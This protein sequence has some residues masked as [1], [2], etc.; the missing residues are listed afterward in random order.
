MLD[1]NILNDYTIIFASFAVYML[2]WRLFHEIN[3]FLIKTKKM[4]EKNK[5]NTHATHTQKRDFF[6]GWQR[7]SH[8]PNLYAKSFY[9]KFIDY[10]KSTT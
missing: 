4:C 3:F 2:M 8:K 5:F 6:S 7:Q 9:L 1:R 10:D